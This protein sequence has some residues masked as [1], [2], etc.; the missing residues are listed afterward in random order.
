MLCIFLCEG[1]VECCGGT[2]VEKVP[3]KWPEQSFVISHADDRQ[4]W[5]KLK[6]KGCSPPIVEAETLLAGVL[7]HKLDLETHRLT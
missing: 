6:K 7:Q 5:K 1:I 3:S 4:L 2:Y